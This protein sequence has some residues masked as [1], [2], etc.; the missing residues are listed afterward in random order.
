[1]IRAALL[2]ALIAMPCGLIT[3]KAIATAAAT[4]HQAEAL[5]LH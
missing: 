5:A 1:M 4:A 2:S 3:A